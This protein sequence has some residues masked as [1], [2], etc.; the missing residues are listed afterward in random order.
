MCYV[1]AKYPPGTYEKAFLS[2]F[3]AI[4]VVPH[5]DLS[6]PELLRQTLLETF[7]PDEADVI[8]AAGSDAEWKSKLTANTE[9]VLKQG[10]FGAPWF[11][12]KNGK[13]VEE[14]FFG[15]DRLVPSI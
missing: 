7:A 9:K 8:L 6:K 14:P 12:V 4:W 15:S 13:G 2:L 1:K 5:R 3:R 11:W 10:A